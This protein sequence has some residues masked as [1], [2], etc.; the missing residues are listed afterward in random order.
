[1][2]N[3]KD[4]K[5]QASFNKQPYIPKTYEQFVLEEQ[6]LEQRDLYPEFNSGDISIQ[7]GYGPCAESYC[8]CSLDKL[9]RDKE[10][11]EKRIRLKY[12]FIPFSIH[13]V[14]SSGCGWND[15]GSCMLYLGSGDDARNFINQVRNEWVVDGGKWVS[16]GTG[17]ITGG[18]RNKLVRVV[19][20]HI[21]GDEEGYVSDNAI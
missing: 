2:V 12:D 8:N 13:I 3:E 17:W 20:A 15:N 16:H 10:L 5:P 4:L 21:N 6:N 7:K 14:N 18:K 19:E 9:Y 1:M 11:I